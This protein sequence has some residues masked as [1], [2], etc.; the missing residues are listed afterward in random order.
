MDAVQVSLT[1]TIRSSMQQNTSALSRLLAA[2]DSTSKACAALYQGLVSTGTAVTVASLESTPKTASDLQKLFLAD[3]PMLGTD[4]QE[5]NT[6]FD[7]LI[8]LGIP[9]D[10]PVITPVL[11]SVD[12]MDGTAPVKSFAWYGQ[13]QLVDVQ[14]LTTTVASPYPGSTTFVKTATNG[15]GQVIQ[16][17]SYTTFDSYANR[18]TTTAASFNDCV[19]LINLAVAIQLQLAEELAR[20]VKQADKLE[21]VVEDNRNAVKDEDTTL[22]HRRSARDD[23]LAE[24]LRQ[25]RVLKAE[26]EELRVRVRSKAGNKGSSEG[27]A[28]S[29]RLQ[30]FDHGM[31]VGPT[32][33]EIARSIR[34]GKPFQ[35]ELA[36]RSSQK[37]ESAH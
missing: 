14:K 30:G 8:S 23:Q 28:D 16:T 9:V 20:L 34:S 7:Y 35:F 27:D 21:D 32:V 4:L 15:S 6:T 1:D 24:A 2:L 13:A 5:A 18:R 26:R 10:A 25:L 12:S 29:H 19:L 3:G 22:N 17:I 33:A 37:N 31:H 36:H 11:V